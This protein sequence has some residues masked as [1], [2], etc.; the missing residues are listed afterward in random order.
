MKNS[1][2]SLVFIL[3]VLGILCS[4]SLGQCPNCSQLLTQGWSYNPPNSHLPGDGGN[5]DEFGIID[6][7]PF[8][9]KVN[10]TPNCRQ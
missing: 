4:D 2:S 10:C 5:N 7:S 1:A 9:V 8:L 6:T 3:F